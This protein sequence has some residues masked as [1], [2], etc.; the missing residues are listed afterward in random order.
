MRVTLPFVCICGALLVF[1]NLA[2][3]EGTYQ[4]TRDSKTIVWNNNP[5]GGDAATWSGGRDRDGYAAGFGTLTWYTAQQHKPAVYAH[6]FGNMVQ[7]KFDGAVNA[8]TKGKTGYASFV[9]GRRM[10][11]WAAGPAPSWR[12]AQ[13]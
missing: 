2:L 10:T 4:R 9:D 12:V 7:G 11:R 13:Q 1:A 6:Y 5:K 8:H 3:G